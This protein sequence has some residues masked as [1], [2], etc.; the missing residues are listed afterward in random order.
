M[1]Y[2]CDFLKIK[3]CSPKAVILA[4]IECDGS[5]WH[6]L[7]TMVR[8]QVMSEAGRILLYNDVHWRSHQFLGGKK[9]EPLSS[10]GRE[11]R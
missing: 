10:L 2:F 9:K 8:T 6:S 7:T 3:V 11:K 1:K 5:S 4:T